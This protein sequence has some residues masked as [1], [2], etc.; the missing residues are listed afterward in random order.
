MEGWPQHA[1]AKNAS[2][3]QK[4]KPVM[5]VTTTDALKALCGQDAAITLIN[6]L[7]AES[8]EK[9]KIPGAINVPLESDDFVARVEQAAGAKDMPIVVYCASPQCDS[10]EKGAR[11]LETAGF[12]A[13]SRYVG[14]AEFYGELANI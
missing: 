1:A 4:G 3:V 5:R 10:S 11:K 6:T 14:G 13:V 8:F 12:T 9:T 7:E 2:F